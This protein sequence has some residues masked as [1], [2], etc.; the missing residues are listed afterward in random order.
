MTSWEHW[1]NQLAEAMKGEHK[2]TGFT[3]GYRA[4]HRLPQAN[5]D[6]RPVVVRLADGSTVRFPTLRSANYYRENYRP[7][8]DRGQIEVDRRPWYAVLDN[9][10]LAELRLNVRNGSALLPMVRVHLNTLHAHPIAA[11]PEQIDHARRVLERLAA[12][13]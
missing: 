8:R 1:T 4:A 7:A 10:I 2:M 12:L 9:P 11:N 3:S 6:P 13:S 5:H